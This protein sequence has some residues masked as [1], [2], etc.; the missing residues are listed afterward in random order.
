MLS[1]K[2]EFMGREKQRQGRIEQIH[3]TSLGMGLCNN[4]EMTTTVIH[5]VQWHL[6]SNM[7]TII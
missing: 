2:T 3:A 7:E 5:L 6:N 4:Q 1:G